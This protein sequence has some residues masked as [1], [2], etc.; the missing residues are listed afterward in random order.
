MGIKRDFVFSVLKNM[1][2]DIKKSIKYWSELSD[3]DI[4]TA[5]SMLKAGRF[6]YCLFMC[7]L[8]IEKSLKAL[9]VKLTGASAPY[10]HNLV[11][12]AKK[13]GIEF[14]EEQKNLLADLTEFNLEARYP[15]WQKQFYLKCDKKYTEDYFKR[16]DKLQKWLIKNL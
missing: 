14:S 15:E 5:S 8:A 11:D 16:S 7:H 9:I 13:T 12:L 6:P 2:I 4:I 1:S 10:S 3:Y